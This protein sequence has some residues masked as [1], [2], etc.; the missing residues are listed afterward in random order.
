REAGSSRHHPDRTQLLPHT[1]AS[2]GGSPRCGR[3]C[4]DRS[5]RRCLTTEALTMDFHS[6][7]GNTAVSK[8]LALMSMSLDGYVADRNDGVSD[9]FDWYFQSGNV[10]FHTGGA[11]PMTFKVSEPS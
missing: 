9:V 10:E 11:D 4:A 7:T 1:R 5:R 3:I 2:R 8:V 6:S